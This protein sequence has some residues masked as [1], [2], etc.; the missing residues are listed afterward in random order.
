VALPPLPGANLQWTNKL[1]I[2]GTI[3]VVATSTVNPNPTN[4]T[5]VVAGGNLTLTWPSDH[6]GWTL[7]VQ[8]NSLSV[9]LNTN[10]IDV[11]GSSTTNSV[12]IPVGSTNGVVF[13]RL[14]L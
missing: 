2:N 7:Q 4:V 6:T 8:A 12:T 10:W 13:Y 5:A 11:P 9:G 14:K 3:A 1:A